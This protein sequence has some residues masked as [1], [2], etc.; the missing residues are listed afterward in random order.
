LNFE[1]DTESSSKENTVKPDSN[2]IR[3]VQTI[4][5]QTFIEYYQCVKSGMD[6][7]NLVKKM[8][9]EHQNGRKVLQEQRHLQCDK[10]SK[11]TVTWKH[12]KSSMSQITQQ[13]LMR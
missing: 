5:M 8:M 7:T 13:L 2:I 3:N 9:A 4:G 10:Y 6:A 11:M 1:L 12:L